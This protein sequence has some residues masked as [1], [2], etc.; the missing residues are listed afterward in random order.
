MTLP[1]R[2]VELVDGRDQLY[3]ML[4]DYGDIIFVP[5]RKLLKTMLSENV[6]SQTASLS[7]LEIHRLWPAESSEIRWLRLKLAEPLRFRSGSRLK[8]LSTVAEPL[9]DRR[10]LAIVA[11]SRD[12]SLGRLR[13]MIHSGSALV[14]GEAGVG[15]STLIAAVAR[16]MD[17]ERRLERKKSKDSSDNSHHPPMFWQSSGGRLIAGM[18]YLGQWQQR[19]EEVVAELGDINGVL[20]VENLLDLVSVGGSEPRDSL[21]AFLLPYVRSG[22]LRMVSEATPTELDACQRLL[23]SVIDAL[24]AVDVAHAARTRGRTVEGHAG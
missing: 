9:S 15:K 2:Y 4:P 11:G 14:V 3:L 8:V 13:E 12:H 23:P 24:P 10:N 1:I 7:P 19:L 22:S 20:V 6:R 16:E 17:V 18:R 5:E 21:A